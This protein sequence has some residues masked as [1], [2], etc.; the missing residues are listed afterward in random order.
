MKAECEQRAYILE[1]EGQHQ[2]EIL[3]SRVSSRHRSLQVGGI[4]RSRFPRDAKKP[5]RSSGAEKRAAQMVSK[6]I[7]KGDVAMLKY[8]IAERYNQRDWPARRLEESEGN[9]AAH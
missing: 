2:S 1:D 5:E 4:R 3:S 8:L 7:G 9:H 6:A